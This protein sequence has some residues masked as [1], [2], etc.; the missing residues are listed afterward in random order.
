M[1]A[2]VVTVMNFPN[3]RFFSP[4][5][6][7]YLPVTNPGWGTQ[8]ACVPLR[9]DEH[10]DA[11]V[12]SARAELPE[13]S[14][15]PIKERAQVLYRYRDLLSKSARELAELVHEENGKTQGEALAE[16]EK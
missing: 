8:V 2:E 9:R 7:D 5:K 15:I 4:E 1:T 11:A 3:G 13:W 12:A 10:V 14:G 6:A 16:V